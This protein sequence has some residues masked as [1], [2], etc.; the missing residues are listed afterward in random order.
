MFCKESH[1]IFV[2]VW[3]NNDVLRELGNRQYS[4][5]DR[6]EFN[7]LMEKN[8]SH[9]IEDVISEKLFD[10]KPINRGGNF[11]VAY[12]QDQFFDVP[13]KEANLI[14][15]MAGKAYRFDEI[16]PQHY[17]YAKAVNQRSNEPEVL[18]LLPFS[19]LPID[20]G[21]QH[22]FVMDF[23]NIHFGMESKSNRY[24]HQNCQ[25][26]NRIFYRLLEKTQDAFQKHSLPTNKAIA[27]FLISNKSNTDEAKFWCKK[28]T[29]LGARKEG[30]TPKE[31]GVKCEDPRAQYF[32][33]F[34]TGYDKGLRDWALKHGFWDTHCYLHNSSKLMAAP[35]SY[36]I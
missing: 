13:G 23:A 36:L 11:S 1:P 20:Q 8:F 5:L 30:Y 17:L 2:D 25:Y 3:P 34:E 9:S 32:D 33:G 26:L 28:I 7:D 27:I 14:G 18:A 21:M 22:S 15:F 12:S 24:H 31:L 19:E 29:E 16:A 35:L 10:G 4:N 6:K